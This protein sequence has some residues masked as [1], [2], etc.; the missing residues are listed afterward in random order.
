MNHTPG[1]WSFV[2]YAA[3]TSNFGGYHAKI[4]SRTATGHG[5]TVGKA[6]GDS[7]ATVEANA[8]LMAAAPEM[9]DALQACKNA[10][11]HLRGRADY[12][13]AADLDEVEAQITAAL[14][15]TV[16]PPPKPRKRPSVN[17]S[18]GL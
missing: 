17:D 18:L 16:A 14:E 12:M 13:T 1:P 8:Y 2:G 11:D 3:K 9:R 4:E 5:P 7:R 6:Y 15:K 10:M